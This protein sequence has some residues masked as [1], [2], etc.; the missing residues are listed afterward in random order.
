MELLRSLAGEKQSRRSKCEATARELDTKYARVEEL[1]F[2]VALLVDNAGK[3]GKMQ[4]RLDAKEKDLA[5]TRQTFEAKTA[6]V[7][8]NAHDCGRLELEMKSA[9]APISMGGK[10]MRDYFEQGCM[11]HSPLLHT[12]ASG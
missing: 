2:K 5:S 4:L 11:A 7:N 3:V 8:K 1:E 10:T 9:A 6:D 12:L